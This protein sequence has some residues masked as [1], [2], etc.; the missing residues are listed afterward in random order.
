MYCTNCKKQ[1]SPDARFCGECGLT[2]NKE[3]GNT[4]DVVVYNEIPP[5][6]FISPVKLALLSV[7]TFGIYIIYWF[8]KQWW[9]L[10]KFKKLTIYPFIMALF[11]PFTSYNLFNEIFL[12]KNPQVNTKNDLPGILSTIYFLLNFI[13]GIGNQL[14]NPFQIVLFMLFLPLI[15]VQ[16]F[17]NS[18]ASDEIK[19]KNPGKFNRW[20]MIILIIGGI[21]FTITIS[22]Y[23]SFYII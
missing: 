12:L 2:M 11:A 9:A 20:E 15:P 8:Y 19:Q 3:G 18:L 10:K 14:Q 22:S 17:I 16:N 7:T 13:G 21:L 1:N 5:F 4:A 23:F 6:L